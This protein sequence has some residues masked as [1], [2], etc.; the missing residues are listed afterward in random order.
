M[1]FLR[2]AIK[3]VGKST[4]KLTGAVVAV[5]T[6]GLSRV[7]GV[8]KAATK[9]AQTAKKSGPLGAAVALAGGPIGIGYRA[10]KN[11]KAYATEAVIA[12]TAGVGIASGAA[13]GAWSAAQRGALAAAK[14]ELVRRATGLV[15]QNT[16]TT[17][18]AA[19]PQVAS[20]SPDLDQDVMAQIYGRNQDGFPGAKQTARAFSGQRPDVISS[21]V[22]T[23]WRL[24]VPRR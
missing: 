12:T 15:R 14:G 13:A 8:S 11:P 6:G 3:R 17:K 7:G 23:L 1:S 19:N 2:Q 18:P 5:G 22:G 24:L 16:V 20:W 4:K 9:V 21:L 10:V